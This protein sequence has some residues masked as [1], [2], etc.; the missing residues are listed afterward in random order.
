MLSSGQLG[1]EILTGY[2]V[3]Q[4]AQRCTTNVWN[5]WMMFSENSMEGEDSAEQFYCLALY[6]EHSSKYSKLWWTY[7]DI[8]T[9][10]NRYISYWWIGYTWNES[11]CLDIFFFRLTHWDVNN[12]MLP[13]QNEQYI[14]VYGSPQIRY[15]MFKRAR[16]RDPNAKLF[17]ND[18]NVVAVG[19][20]TN[21]SY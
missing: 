7:S 6:K 12:E 1:R 19:Q 20:R 14:S 5:E 15:D 11:N 10:N 21:V 3:L 4:V 18:Y 8:T 2:S 13:P 17:L 9:R 16:L